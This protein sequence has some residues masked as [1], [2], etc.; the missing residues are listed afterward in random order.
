MRD[1]DRFKLRFGPYK[2]PRFNVG[3]RVRCAVR[4]E[5]VIVGQ[6]DAPIPWPL[7]RVGKWRVPVVY[8]GLARAV[9]REAELAVAHWW[10][11]GLWSVWQWRKALGIGAT[12]K[13][14]SRLRREHF[15]EPWADQ[16]RKKAWAKVGDP[17][18]R[19]KIAEAKRGK[20]RPP[21]VGEAVAAA[22]RGKR[23][24]EATRRKMSASHKRRGTRPPK[25]ARPWT[26][27]EDALAARCRR[28]KCPGGR[29]GRSRRSTTGGGCSKCRTE[30]GPGLES[31]RLGRGPCAAWACQPEFL[32]SF[33][34]GKRTNFAWGIPILTSLIK[35]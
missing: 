29:G 8:K 2:T 11:I 12:T 17:E 22:H 7:C 3:Q 26:A 32:H 34:P 24:S 18:R 28:R 16:M 6:S 14:T 25:A 4:G 20:P 5:V 23:A 31:R 19:A 21:H 15:K 1:A 13:G 30:G 33:R 35:C 9:R 10:G 27:E